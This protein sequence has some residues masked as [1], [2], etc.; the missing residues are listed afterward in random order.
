MKIGI[1]EYL[2]NLFSSVDE[3]VDKKGVPIESF[4]KVGGL[5]VGTLKNKRFL[6]NKD[7]YQESL[8]F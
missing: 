1:Q 3:I 6:W 4:A 7:N 2:E 5:N 8:L